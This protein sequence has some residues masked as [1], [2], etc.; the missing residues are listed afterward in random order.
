MAEAHV[1]VSMNE[2][3]R[4]QAA[5]TE[6]QALREAVRLSVQA[7]LAAAN[8]ARLTDDG[9]EEPE[10]DLPEGTMEAIAD[11]MLSAL[12]ILREQIGPLVDTA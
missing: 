11:G 2:Y 10:E 8:V 6:L 4:M 3:R 5:E 12:A 7:I 1:Y 9:S